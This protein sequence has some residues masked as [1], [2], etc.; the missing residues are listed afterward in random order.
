MLQV[1]LVYVYFWFSKTLC[2]ENGRFLEWKIHL[3]LCVF[4]FYVFI[5]FH[6][7]KQ[8]A[9]PLGFLL[10]VYAKKWQIVTRD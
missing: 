9:K 5:V 7:V 10:T 3:D 1:I 8:S 6:L 2:L 4:Q